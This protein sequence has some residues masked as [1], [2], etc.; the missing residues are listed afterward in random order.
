ML[1]ITASDF[2]SRNRKLHNVKREYVEKLE[3]IKKEGTISSAEFEK[4]FGVRI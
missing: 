3:A 1:N 2:D 4:R